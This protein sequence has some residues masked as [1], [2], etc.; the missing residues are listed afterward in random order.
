[1]WSG[2]GT[3]RC[4]GTCGTTRSGMGGRRGHRWDK[5]AGYGR[6]AGPRALDRSPLRE[7]LA[8]FEQ[9]RAA[10]RELPESRE[11]TEQLINLCFEQRNALV[12]LGEFAR[13]GEGLNEARALADGL[14]DQRRLGG[15]LGDL[16]FLYSNLGEPGRG[17]EAGE[18][19][20]AIAEAGGGLGLRVVANC[21]LGVALWFAGDPRRAAAALRAALK[22]G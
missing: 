3:T 10:L 19:A 18:S 7:A 14:G 13:V 1:M 11:R 17:I 22:G 16:A 8:H 15:A 12:G 2:W 20:C 9:A 6:Q 21:Y 5:P 4:A